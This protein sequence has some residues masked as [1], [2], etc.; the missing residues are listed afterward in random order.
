MLIDVFKYRGILRFGDFSRMIF[1]RDGIPSIFSDIDKPIGTFPELTE[2][3]MFTSHG[4][5][6]DYDPGRVQKDFEGAGILDNSKTEEKFGGIDDRG[7]EFNFLS[8]HINTMTSMSVLGITAILIGIILYCSSRDCW[9]E[10]WSTLKCCK[11]T[12][13]PHHGETL[14]LPELPIIGPS[15]SNTATAP[16]AIEMEALEQAQ[17]LK[18]AKKQKKSKEGDSNDSGEGS[19]RG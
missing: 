6:E 2:A 4:Q 9:S 16:T 12:V 8:L 15:Y 3:E 10:I 17:Y 19:K 18:L 1:P 7:S 5:Q 11:C 14:Y 13:G